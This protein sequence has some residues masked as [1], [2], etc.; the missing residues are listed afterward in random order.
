MWMNICPIFNPSGKWIVN[1]IKYP[2]LYA[3]YHLTIVFRAFKVIKRG[4]KC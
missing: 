1:T 4:K 3:G 2:E